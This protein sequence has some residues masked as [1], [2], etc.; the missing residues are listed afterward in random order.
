MAIFHY[1]I[2]IVGRSKG[3]SV[4]SASAYLNGDVMKNEETGRIS[5]Y[6]SKKEVVYTRLMM[7]ENAPPEWQIVPEENIKRFQKSVR[8]KRSEDK[9][10]ALEKFKITFQKQRLWN[11]VLKIEKSA[12]AQLGRSFEFALPKE[13]SR[14]EQIQYTADYIK[15]TF[16]DKGMCADWSIHDKGDGNPH[17]HL[18]LTMRPFNPDHSWGKK[19]VKDWGFVRDKSGNIVIDESHPNWW[20]DKKNPDR[21]GIRIPVLDE[22]GIQKIGARNRLQ[23][24][25]VLTDA[26]GWN[27]PK[28][29]ELWRSEWAKVCNEHLPLHNQVDHR[30]YEKQG[31]LQIPTIHE[32]ADAR[33]IE[34][35]F[36]AGQEIK[37]SWK[38]AE[39][40]II[41]QQNT[42]LQK[43]LD[44][45]GK[46]S[47]ALSLW[48]E[49]LNDIRRKPGNYTLNGVHDWANRRTADLNGRNASGNAEPGHP[50]L[51]YA[52][53]ESEIAKIKQRVIRAA[54]HFAKYRGTTFQDGRTENED[55]TFGKRK[56]AMAEIGTDSEQRKQFIAETE[57]RIAEL[58]QQIEKGRDIDE[59]IQ[60]IKE[61]RTVGR[62][63]ALDRGDTRRT[64]TERPAYR[65]T[66]DAAQRISDLEREIKQREQSI[67]YSIIK[68]RL[69]D[70]RQSI[71]DRERKAAKRNVTIE[72]CQ[73]KIRCLTQERDY[74]RTHQKIVEIPVEKPVLYE[75]CEACNRTAYQN[76]KAKYETQKERLAG[77]YKAKTV[78]FQTTLFLLAWYSLTTTLFQAVQSDMFLVDCKSF[79]NDLAS[80]IQTFVG[81]TIDAGHS[82]AQIST[83]IPNA[84]IAGMVYWLLL[85]LIVGICMAGTG[86][87]A[88]LIEIK[89][90]EL[91]KKNCWDVITLLMILTSVAIVIYFGE[92][93]KKVLSV[94]L[95][96]LFVL[97]QGA[98]VGIR[99]YL[100]VWLEKR[101]Y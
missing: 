41:K 73:D 68:E 22:N 90:I 5:Y 34:Q 46:V 63:S 10:A 28:N 6:T 15:K 40:Q 26:T 11:E 55:R 20:Q 75:K 13:W 60:R 87:L 66:E 61:R 51:S 84:F 4:I 29:C 39:N 98:Y 70:G 23:W 64:G 85:I 1:T 27:N 71:A 54:Q 35:K 83:K 78:M 36:L 53:T 56:S 94:N 92:S 49:R 9:E 45:F 101:P 50:T 59:R 69:E 8:Y 100:K 74:A 24:K 2:K 96:L 42:L 58:E 25:R 82:A 7:C 12:D 76:A 65:G 37:G 32:G 16:V 31:K 21:H 88:I 95:L 93:I 52:G 97:S 3:K 89:V 33:K 99:C 17:V 19:E 14:Q 48:K 18:L 44:T 77:Q 72:D 91:Y 30:S 79:F 43:I 57:H 38:V 47:G 62:T 81:W 80:F 67:E 86:M